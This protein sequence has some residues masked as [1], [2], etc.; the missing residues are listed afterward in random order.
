[1]S[2]GNA[3]VRIYACG[4]FGL[5][6]VRKLE[7]Y[8]GMETCFIDASSANRANEI[9]EDQLHLIQG[10]DGSGKKRSLNVKPISDE[11]PAILD[12]FTP[13]DFNIVVF[14]AGGGSGSVIGPLLLSNLIKSEH[15]A[16]VVMVGIL[17][18]SVTIK[19][20]LDVIKGFEALSAKT[21]M[22]VAVSY[23]QNDE[24]VPRSVVDGEVIYVLKALSQMTNQR[25]SELDTKDVDNWVF[26]NRVTGVSAQLVGMQVHDTR[27]AAMKI[28]EPI[29][30]LTLVPEHDRDI[31]Y[32]DPYYKTTG[33]YDPQ[34]TD[35]VSNELHF[36][37]SIRNMENSVQT[38]VQR[39]AD[40]ER[41]HA[42]QRGRS[43]ILD[44]DD[45]SDND[46][47]VL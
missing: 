3:K 21:N 17:E 19:N 5:N 28:P 38:L 40:L 23:H 34:E 1:M 8:D 7:P 30:V 37:L 12:K 35:L 33:I 27:K 42:A 2:E 39:E 20:T 44:I 11:I 14:S 26:F 41:S 9:P 4:G 16:V 15:T 22:P 24:G 29:S 46:G 45:E 13:A 18:S 36:V 43:T 31:P 10:I 25:H 6:V 32:G 47:L